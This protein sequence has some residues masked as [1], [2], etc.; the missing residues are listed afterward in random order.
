MRADHIEASEL[1]HI[2]AALTPQNRLAM[3]VAMATGLRIGDVL[4]I[5]TRQLEEAKD[6]RITVCEQKTGKRRRLTV[7]E[8]LY[9]RCLAMAGRLYVFS[10][11]TDWRKPRSRQAVWK[12]LRRAAKL[13][14]APQH[15]SPHSARKTWAVAEYSKQGD[16]K[17]I[18]R[19]LNHSDPAVTAL[20]A[21]ADALTSRKR[22][23]PIG[24]P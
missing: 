22:P 6:R 24:R 9:M 17:R 2:L 21:M 1:Q 3:E 10:G 7:P 12:D 20:Y 23:S 14:R 11:R 16:I 13:F 18:Q 8:P 15:V 19:L 5:K 4:Q